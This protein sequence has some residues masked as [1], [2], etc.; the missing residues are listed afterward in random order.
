M[1]H[2]ILISAAAVLLSGCASAA[3]R[4][5]TPDA[6]GV[7]RALDP[8]KQFRSMLLQT[9]KRTQTV[10]MASARDGSRL[11]RKLNEAVDGAVAR[12][13]DKWQHNLM[14]S[15]NELGPDDLRQVCSALESGDQQTFKRFAMRV[16]P[17]VQ[18]LNEPL[19]REA[20]AEILA[21][22]W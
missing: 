11:D 8:D 6:E 19:L 17:T 4:C 18:E 10:A 21:A 1:T 22:V 9:A 14:V 12:H 3:P 16:G 2:H 15:W 7:V 5:S 13:G 20:G